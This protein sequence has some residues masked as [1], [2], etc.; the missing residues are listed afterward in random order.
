MP[1]R[2]GLEEAIRRPLMVVVERDPELMEAVRR[3]D[4]QRQF[5]LE[6]ERAGGGMRG[7]IGG[8]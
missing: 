8:W 1:C 2:V 3:R 4:P 5:L 6:S 7:P